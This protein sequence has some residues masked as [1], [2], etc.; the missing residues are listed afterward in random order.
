[1]MLLLVACAPALVLPDD[2]AVDGVTVGVRTL[3]VDGRTVD[4]WYPAEDGGTP[5]VID[6]DVLL[7]DAF[8]ERVGAVDLPDLPTRAVRDAEPLVTRDP[9]PVILF[10]HGFGG[11]RDQS[12]DFTVHL[13]SRGYVVIAPDHVGRRFED[14]LPCLFSPALEGCDLSGMATDPGPDDLAAVKAWVDA[15]PDD[16]P[17]AAI[18]DPTRLGLAGHSAGG[19]TVGTFGTANPDVQAIYTMAMGPT[20]PRD[21]PMRSLAGTCDGVVAFDDV[22]DGVALSAHAELV[23]V[24]GAGHLAFSDMCTL[25]LESLSAEW[26]DGRDDLN[27]IIYDSLRSLGTDGCPGRVPAVEACDGYADLAVT[28]EIIRGDSTQ[29]FDGLLRA[30]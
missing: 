12:V 15:L 2:P 8:V 11:F 23:P 28:A 7:T 21:V 19:T 6:L 4:V 9:Y 22:A 30:E 24:E 26:L 14:V 1:M 17:L 29:F 16:D 10:S 3:E 13:A 20:V 18:V 25:D 27:D 5:E